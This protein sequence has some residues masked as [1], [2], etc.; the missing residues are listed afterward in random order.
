MGRPVVDRKWH[1][2]AGRRRELTSAAKACLMIRPVDLILG[3]ASPRRIALLRASGVDFEQVDSGIDESRQDGEPARDYALRMACEKALKVSESY[4]A[5]CV[6]AADTVVECD[7]EVL[8][9]PEKPDDARRMLRALSGKTHVVVTAFAL[10]RDGRIVERAPVL[11]QVTFRPLADDEID[12]Y[13]ASG[14]PFDKAGSYGI[15]GAGAG[16]ISRVSGSREN[17]MG[18]PVREVLE[19]LR[20]QGIRAA[21]TDEPRD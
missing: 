9:K 3:S 7:R 6:L 16:F 10:A 5:R 8:L 11:S 12:N 1:R 14:E 19:A 13:V 4:P 20:R 2:L 17:V 15:Q 18:L 21:R